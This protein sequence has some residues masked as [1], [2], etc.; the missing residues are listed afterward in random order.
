MNILQ[1][2][3]IAILGVIAAV[4]L[5]S[6]KPEFG[7]FFIIALSF[8]FLGQGIR[9]MSEVKTE[10]EVVQFFYRENQYYYKLLFKLIGITYLCEFTSGICKDA[11]YQSIAAQVELMGKMLILVSGMPVLL[12]MIET[13]WKYEI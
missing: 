10:L 5:K 12:T 6:Y 2:A 9:L 7:M 4:I 11:G 3:V 13:L 1:I 8:L